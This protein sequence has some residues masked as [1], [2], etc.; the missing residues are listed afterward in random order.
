MTIQISKVKVNETLKGQWAVTLNM[1]L[2]EG[3]EEL[4]NQDFSEDYKTG[5][6][7]ANIGNKFKDKMQ[8]VINKYKSEQTILTHT[9]L[10][11]V[12]TALQNQLEV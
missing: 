4:F 3:T 11:T 7:I 6:D 5:D 1:K 8:E 12:V 10:D 9:K 2:M